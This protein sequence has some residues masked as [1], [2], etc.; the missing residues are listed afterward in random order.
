ML[1]V[2]VSMSLLAL[3]GAPAFAGEPTEIVRAFYA[4]P[5]SETMPEN[6]AKLTGPL[7]DL[8]KASE[9]AWDRDETVCLDFAFSI[10]AQDFDQEEIT[11]SLKLDETVSG[12]TARVTANFTNFGNPTTVEWTLVHSTSGWLVSDI[13]SPTS[14]WRASTVTCE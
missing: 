13:A 7:L 1:K 6:R 9:E 14:D 3:T 10:D 8:L 2:L 4:A 12:E 11:R 5:G